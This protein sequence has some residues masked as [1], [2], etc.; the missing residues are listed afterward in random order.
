V[1]S[2][3]F[4]VRDGYVRDG[5]AGGVV[6]A[7]KEYLQLQTPLLDVLLQLKL[8]DSRRILADLRFRFFADLC[9][10]DRVAE[11]EGVEYLL[12]P[13]I[14]SGLK[15]TARNNIFQRN[16]FST[17]FVLPN[18]SRLRNGQIG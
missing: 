10:A 16:L 3:R 4:L 8:Q 7:P 11:G 18:G 13:G 5:K 9:N 15:S 6:L 12:V 2:S 14:L 1:L 17:M